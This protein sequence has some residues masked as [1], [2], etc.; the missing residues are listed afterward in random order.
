MLDIVKITFPH[1]FFDNPLAKISCTDPLSSHETLA[2]GWKEV[3]T[4]I[5]SADGLG[6]D[7]DV[8]LPLLEKVKLPN[9]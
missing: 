5:H 6:P 2:C 9:R 7:P 4:A 3:T 1:P 8:V